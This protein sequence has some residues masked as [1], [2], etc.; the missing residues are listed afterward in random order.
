MAVDNR[1][2]YIG[3]PKII[4]SGSELVYLAVN[5]NTGIVIQDNSKNYKIGEWVTINAEDALDYDERVLIND[6]LIINTQTKTIILTPDIPFE[7]NSF[8]FMG[9]VVHSNSKLSIDKVGD[10][11]R[12]YTLKPEYVPYNGS[13]IIEN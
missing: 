5:P 3:Y 11:D 1:L 6:N 9:V 7:T 10:W 12:K 4:K 8:G 13:V 2:E